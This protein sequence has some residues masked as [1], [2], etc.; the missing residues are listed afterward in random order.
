MEGVWVLQEWGG[1]GGGA[2]PQLVAD[3]AAGRIP[4]S[5]QAWAQHLACPLGRP[6]AGSVG[7]DDKITGTYQSLQRFLCPSRIL[8]GHPA[9]QE[10]TAA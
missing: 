10:D 2:T 5:L 1:V 9:L 6:I 3:E 8:D 4:W 7:Y